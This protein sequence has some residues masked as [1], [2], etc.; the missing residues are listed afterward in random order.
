M[1]PG[2]LCGSQQLGRDCRTEGQ[3]LG[4]ESVAPGCRERGGIE[5]GA[6]R[7]RLWR[8]T[9]ASL[10]QQLKGLQAEAHREPKAWAHEG[11][12]YANSQFCNSDV[13]GNTGW[14]QALWAGILI[15]SIIYTNMYIYN[16][17]YDRKVIDFVRIQANLC[18]SASYNISLLCDLGQV[19]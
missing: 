19:T 14:W 2:K 17:W 11:L 13:Q 6:P 9:V 16:L 3:G 4:R 15:H 12:G 7:L 1:H 10:G 8:G 18:S 5:G